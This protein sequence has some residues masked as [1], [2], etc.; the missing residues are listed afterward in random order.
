MKRC[1]KLSDTILSHDNRSSMAGHQKKLDL[2]TDFEICVKLD[3]LVS[4]SMD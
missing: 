1:K 2:S 4:H 3:G